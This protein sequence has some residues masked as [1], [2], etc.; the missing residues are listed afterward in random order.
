M[1]SNDYVWLRYADLQQ[2]SREVYFFSDLAWGIES[3]LNYLFNAIETGTAPPNPVDLDAALSRA[4][5]S[6]ARLFRSRTLTLKTWVLPTEPIRTN[7]TAEAHI[8]LARI[9]SSVKEAD[10]KILLDAGFGY[11]DREIAIRHASTPGAIRVRLSRLRHKLAA[12]DYSVARP[13]D[14]HKAVHPISTI[15]GTKPQPANKAA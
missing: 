11:T 6:G 1:L 13:V 10:R 7:A 5:A 15:H 2:R 12:S 14:V 3:A 8:E 4:I 9:R